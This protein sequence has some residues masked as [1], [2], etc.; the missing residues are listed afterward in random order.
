MIDGHGDD[1]HRY[2]GRITMN[3]SSNIYPCADLSGLKEHLAARLDVIGAYPEP[4][5]SALERTI[6]EAH[7]IAA[8]SVMVTAGAT[9]AVYLIAQAFA[10][11]P[12]R[13]ARYAVRRPAFSE[14]EDACRMFGYAPAVSPDADGDD[15]LR[16]ICH[17][18]NPTGTAL[19]LGAIADAARRG[20]VTVVDQSYED[21]TLAPVFTAVEA[22][23]QPGIILLHSMTK[24]YAVP[25]LRL[26]YVTAQPAVIAAIRRC[27]RPWAVNALAIEAGMYLLR[28]GRPA[29]PDLRRYLAD[30]AGLRRSLCG[31]PGISVRPTATNFMLAE[32]A[33]GTAAGL[34]EHLARRHGMLIRDCSNFAGLSPRHFRVAARTPEDNRRLVA[35][36]GEYVAGWAVAGTPETA[37]GV[38]GKLK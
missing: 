6:A 13:L 24:T 26:G 14:Y 12:R 36:I 28:C 18:D 8:D 19:P 15:V 7:G 33:R 11:G 3:F 34:K 35:A 4:W 22:L 29:I 25:G 38:N 31:V 1:M 17:P 9:E 21:Y 32:L 5:P 37:G 20:G 23:R 10:T 2:G 16:W 30:A 27:A